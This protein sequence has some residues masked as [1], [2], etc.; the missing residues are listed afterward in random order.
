M[1]FTVYGTPVPQGS[2]KAFT[3]KGWKRPVLTSDNARLKS[4][5]QLVAEAAHLALLE[6]PAAERQLILDA[7]T[8]TITFALPRPASLPKR[9]T[10]HCKRPDLDK[11]VRAVSDSLTGVLFLDD[12]QV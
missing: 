11:L 2:T 8:L 12:C 3:P 1:T 4:W 9:I 6:Q 10:T 5:R 7:V